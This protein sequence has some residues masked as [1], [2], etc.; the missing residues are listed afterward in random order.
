MPEF[1]NLL[2][3]I[4]PKSVNVLPGIDSQAGGIDPLESIPGLLKRLQI[5]AQ[6]TSY[7]RAVQILAVLTSGG[8]E[9]GVVYV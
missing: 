4:E 9:A 3:G 6:Y 1:R 8:G 2:P 7:I 5:R